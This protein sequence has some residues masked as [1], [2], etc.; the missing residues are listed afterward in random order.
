MRNVLLIGIAIFAFTGCSSPKNEKASQESKVLEYVDFNGAAEE[1]A[2]PTPDKEGGM[3][4]LEAVNKRKSTKEFKTEKLDIQTISN[5]LWVANGFNREDK[6]TVPTAQNKQEL[7]LYVVFKD[8]AYFYDAKEHSLVLVAKNDIR[9]DL[10]LYNQTYV[11]DA[12]LNILIVSDLE[13]AASRDAAL[14]D[15]GFI[16]QNIYLYSV[17]ADLGAVA[18]VSFN[19]DALKED[20]KLKEN[21][22]IL[23]NLTVGVPNN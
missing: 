18:R 1:I 17:S 11:N 6:R 13:L 15:A 21:Q 8:A 9:P 5:L 22:E 14:M 2:L 7:E 23:L 16:G 12:F 4:L 3:A 10:I 19:A 20:L